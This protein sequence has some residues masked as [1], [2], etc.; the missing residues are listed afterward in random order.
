MEHNPY[1]EFATAINNH[2]TTKVKKH[3]NL[4]SL[5]LGTITS[6]G[7]LVDGFK[8]EIRDY[9]IADYLTLDSSY[10][11]TT[12]ANDNVLTPDELKPLKEGDRVLVAPINN[13]KD[14]V[15][16]CRVKRHA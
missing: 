1:R 15:I 9:Y 11:T 8:H 7:L 14:Y 12:T 16:T 13:G 10:M 6:S 5:C 2:A 3:T 4:I